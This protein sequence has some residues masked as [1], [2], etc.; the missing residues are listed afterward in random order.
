MTKEE[1]VAEVEKVI[2]PLDERTKQAIELAMKL[3][4]QRTEPTCEL[5]WQGENPSFE[6]ASKLS[7]KER[8]QILQAL[9]RRNRTWLEQKLKEL[10]ARWLLVIDGEILR[11]G[12]TLTEQ[13]TDEEL[14][15]ICHKWGKLP[16]LFM[17]L[18]PI[19]ETSR[20]YLTIYENDAYPTVALRVLSDSITCDFIA[21]FDTGASEVYLDADVLERQGII[22]ITF[23][24]PIYESIH[25]G[26]PF[27]YVVKSI[28]LALLDENGLPNETTMFSVCVFNWHQS[29]FVAINPNRV[30]L[31]GRDLCLSLQPQINLDF[32]QHQ[33]TIRWR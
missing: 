11:Y 23:A 14:M 15:S 28:R 26:Q 19:E 33:T 25:L 24:D 32:S 30:A 17:P 13:L 20:W 18:R 12:T 9:E 5:Q 1:I 21:D 10:K 27:E 29:P 22:Q 7:P 16:L 31:V 6:E 8:G 3:I 4:E 2:G